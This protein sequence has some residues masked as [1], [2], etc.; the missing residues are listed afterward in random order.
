MRV[1]PLSEVTIESTAELFEE[2][3]QCWRSQLFWDYQPAVSLIS[4]YIESR[5]LPGYGLITASGRVVGYSYYTVR[6]PIGYVGNLFV[7]GKSASPQ[8][9]DQL[10]DPTVSS[11]RVWGRVQRIEC[12]AFSFNCDLAPLFTRYGFEALE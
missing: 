8:S 3:I 12:Q 5:T 1:V 2:E 4:K 7:R 10:L 9:Y 11:L 6:H